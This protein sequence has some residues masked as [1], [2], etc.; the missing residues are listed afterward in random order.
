[1]RIASPE[2]IQTENNW[3]KAEHEQH[4]QKIKEW[5]RLAFGQMDG[6]ANYAFPFYG[7]PESKRTSTPSTPVFR[8]VAGT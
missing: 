6:M 4:E 8:T 2:E 3:I 5:N 1:M 7:F